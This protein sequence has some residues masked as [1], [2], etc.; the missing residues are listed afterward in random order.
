[1]ESSTWWR[2]N[3]KNEM[4]GMRTTLETENLKNRELKWNRARTIGSGWGTGTTSPLEMLYMYSRISL[5]ASRCR[6]TKGR[7]LGGGCPVYGWHWAAGK[8]ARTQKKQHKCRLRKQDEAVAP[9]KLTKNKEK[10]NF[11][12]LAATE[13][14]T[15]R[16]EER[17]EAI[18][19]ERAGKRKPASNDALRQFLLL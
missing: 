18:T 5:M 16:A 13:A 9:K 1:M 7:Q 15:F 2:R 4:S 6:K 14:K 11:A 10:E 17:E 12:P 3:K 19:V 8:V